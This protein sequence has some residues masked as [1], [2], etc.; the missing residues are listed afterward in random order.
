VIAIRLM[1]FSKGARLAV[2]PVLADRGRR[3]LRIYLGAN[4]EAGLAHVGGRR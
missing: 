2:T 1:S 3:A 4:V